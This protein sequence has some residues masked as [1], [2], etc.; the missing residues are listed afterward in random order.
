MPENDRPKESKQ[1]TRLMSKHTKKTKGARPSQEGL[2]LDE[3]TLLRLTS[4]IEQNLSSKS[5]NKRKHPPTI[6][7]ESQKKRQRQRGDAGRKISA[8]ASSRND[9][10]LSDIKA[11]GGDERDLELIGDVNSSD[12]D[13]ANDNSRPF[14]QSLKDELLAFSKELGL[15]DHQPSEASEIDEDLSAAG[16][17]REGGGPAQEAADAEAGSLDEEGGADGRLS[18]RRKPGDLVSGRA[19]I[20]WAKSRMTDRVAGRFL[21]QEQTG[22]PRSFLRSMGQQRTKS[23]HSQPPWNH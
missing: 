12:E 20:H 10:L 8:K 7:A 16:T 21:S 3:T 15:A 18:T 17:R 14:D 5:E 11:L 2:G 9:E 23:G 13:D 4:N 6:A 19:P 22:M 1:Y